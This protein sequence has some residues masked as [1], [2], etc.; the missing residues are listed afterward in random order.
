MVKT[1]SIVKLSEVKSDIQAAR[2]NTDTSPSDAQIKAENYKKGKFR[3]NGLVIRLENPK[4]SIR[5]GTS[6]DGKEWSIKM[7]YDYGYIG[8]TKSKADGGA[9][10]VFVG[11]HPDSKVVHVIDQMFKGKFDEHKCV[12]GAK[13][14][15][16]AKKVY[17]A[18]YEKGWKCGPINSMTVDQFK[19]WVKK[20]NTG[21]PVSD[22]K[23][24]KIAYD[25]ADKI[26][27]AIYNKI[28]APSPK[29]PDIAPKQIPKAPSVVKSVRPP[30]KI[31]PPTG[32]VK[33]RPTRTLRS[34]SNITTKMPKK[35]KKRM[36]KYVPLMDDAAKK[37]GVDPYLLKAIGW[38]ESDFMPD[39][40]SSAGASGL[41][42][43]M[44]GTAKILSVNNI[45]NPRENTY[46]AAKHI[47]GLGILSHNVPDE[48]KTDMILAKYNF[49]SGNVKKLFNKYDGDHGKVLDNLPKETKG[50]IRGIKEKLKALEDY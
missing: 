20:G 23:L 1:P 41:F 17:L 46:G 28:A 5:S 37:Y 25:V 49:G 39:A 29:S 31:T 35:I 26:R 12:I 3:W 4:G 36:G 11:P 30:R 19:E 16:E 42:Q 32:K 22:Q 15:E 21:K 18:N 47:K 44:P 33:K 43:L 45:F 13:D 48:Y 34:K 9:V 38:Q 7:K 2:R 14:K 6:D 24:F 27:Y 10:D 50:Y 40:V 8:S